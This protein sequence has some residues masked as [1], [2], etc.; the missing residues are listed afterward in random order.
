[1]HGCY[2]RDSSQAEH[3]CTFGVENLDISKLFHLWI[4]FR[5][6]FAGTYPVAGHN[7]AM[8]TKL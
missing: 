7:R 8:R 5:V 4:A 6:S 2:R 1:M 3:S